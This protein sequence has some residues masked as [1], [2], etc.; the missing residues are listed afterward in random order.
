MLQTAYSNASNNELSLSSTAHIMFDGGSQKSYITA[1][2]KK[3]LHLK[4]IRNE[5]IILKTFGSTEG[6]VSIVDVVNLKTKCRNNEFVNIE[7]LWY[8][9]KR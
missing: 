9:R 4:T 2:L 1:H 8:S 6:K 5:K 3:K 7:A